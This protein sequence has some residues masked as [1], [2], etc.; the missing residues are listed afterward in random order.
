[1]MQAAQHK[2]Y[3]YRWVNLAVFGLMG[4][5]MGFSV[6]GPTAL[7][8]SLAEEWSVE[9]S[10]ANLALVV[11]GGIFGAL[12]GVPAG[13]AC[14]R[15]GYKLPSVIGATVAS[16][17][18]LLRGT[19]GSWT[20]FLVYNAIASLGV[21]ATMAGSGTL[22]QNWFPPS[23]IG[24]A[25]GLSMIL[26]PLGSAVGS[27]AVFPLIESAGWSRMWWI[28][29]IAYAVPTLLSWILYVERPDVPPAPSSARPVGGAGF[30][31]DLKQVMNR[32]N[33]LL[34]VVRIAFTGLL[35]VAPALLPVL[36]ASRAVPPNT[37][38]VVM[39]LFNLVG[40]PAMAWIP[41][42]AFHAGWP[43]RAMALALLAAAIAFVATFYVPLSA[44]LI[45]PAAA[46]SAVVG[47]ALAVIGPLS[48][49]VGMMQ[50]GVNAGNVGTLSGV[51]STVMGLGRLVLPP[52]VG[53]LVDGV[54]A[55]AGAWAL[56][57]VVAVAGVVT[58]ISIPESRP[59]AEQR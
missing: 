9:F 45:W 31:Q 48:M 49:S 14:D 56:A 32:T 26:A 57:I 37:I 24:Q 46:L 44:H 58:A 36:F 52:I 17:G 40:V 30:V 50:P 5:A 11:L 19:A 20:A 2:V 42:P 15:F 41:G 51:A 55:T 25:N 28:L 6:M 8:G 16:V 34:Q 21:S 13:R 59:Q 7:V 27:Y 18:L 39:G 38:G 22:V 43:K 12:L 53:A 1:M 10:D 47:T 54:S 23:E 33:V 4:F 35:S 29:G 3:R